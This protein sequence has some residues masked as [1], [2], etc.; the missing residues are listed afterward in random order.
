MVVVVT[1]WW[2]WGYRTLYERR[3]VQ[4]RDTLLLGDNGR[5]LVGGSREVYL[6]EL[7]RPGRSRERIMIQLPKPAVYHPAG[8]EIGR[9]VFGMMNKRISWL[10]DGRTERNG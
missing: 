5:E 4:K 9:V 2:C 6:I 10:R 3:D 1:W 8:G 7:P